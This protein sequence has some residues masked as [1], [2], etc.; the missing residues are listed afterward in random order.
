MHVHVDAQQLLLILVQ[1]HEDI[2]DCRAAP[3][4]PGGKQFGGAELGGERL[5]V[6]QLQ[7]TGKPR[8]SVTG[9]QGCYL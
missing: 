5:A 4:H 7:L 9:M 2:Q 8:G 1:T 3:I 6:V